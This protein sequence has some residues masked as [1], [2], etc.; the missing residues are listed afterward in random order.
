ML[1][2]LVGSEMCIR[3]ST[4]CRDYSSLSRYLTSPPVSNGPKAP[5]PWVMFVAAPQQ[6]PSHKR[7]P[8]QVKVLQMRPYV[9]LGTYCSVVVP[10]WS[11]MSPAEKDAAKLRHKKAWLNHNECFAGEQQRGRH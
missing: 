2:S 1:R 5:E 10:Y 4:F 9:R 8:G 6:A 7:K 11:E 3:D